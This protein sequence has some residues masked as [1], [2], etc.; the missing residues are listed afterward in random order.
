[1]MQAASTSETSENLYQSTRRNNLEDSPLHTR[2][3]E[4]LKSNFYDIRSVRFNEE[5]KEYGDFSGYI[6]EIFKLFII[7]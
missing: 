3:R 2:R 4:N 6:V 1:M 7:T 5:L